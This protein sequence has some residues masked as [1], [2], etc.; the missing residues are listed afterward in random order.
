MQIDIK[1]DKYRVLKMKSAQGQ[2]ASVT[3]HTGENDAV[4]KLV[5]KMEGKYL[6]D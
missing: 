5:D 3:Y 1:R 2:S 4:R 6:K